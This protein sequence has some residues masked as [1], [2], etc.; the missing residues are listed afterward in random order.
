M[1]Y[2]MVS[3]FSMKYEVKSVESERDQ[4]KGRRCQT[5]FSEGRKVTTL[6]KHIGNVPY[7]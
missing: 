2:I 1:K 6:Q 3:V 4:G 7:C 5:A